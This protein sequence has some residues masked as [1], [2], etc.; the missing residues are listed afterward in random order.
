MED[1]MRQKASDLKYFTI[2]R[3]RLYFFWNLFA[4][5]EEAMIKPNYENDLQHLD[6]DKEGNSEEETFDEDCKCFN[7]STKC[8]IEHLVGRPFGLCWILQFCRVC[9][10]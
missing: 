2:P 3:K 9:W 10:G 4:E 1:K 6:D 8:L 5:R 7:I